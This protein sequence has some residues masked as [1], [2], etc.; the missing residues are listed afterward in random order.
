MAKGP[1]KVAGAGGLDEF[2]LVERYL[3]PLAGPGG[4]GLVDDAAVLVPPDGRELVMT[5]DTLVA[6]VH[7]PADEAPAAIAAKALR[8]NLSDLAAMGAQPWVYT[9]NLGL[10]SAPHAAWM[11]PFCDALAAD[12][13]TFGIELVGGDTVSTPGAA[14]FTVTALGV[15]APGRA[16]RRGGGRPG[17]DVWVSGSVG[18]AGLGL[19]LVTGDLDNASD[20]D[21]RFL[22]ERYRRPTPR[23]GLGLALAELAGIGAAADVSDGLVADLG[24]VCAASGCA[25]EIF[26]DSIPLS[27]SAV[28]LVRNNQGL[29]RSLLTSGDDYELVF[30]AVAAAADSVAALATTAGVAVTRIGRLLPGNGVQVLATPTGPP[31]EVMD[32]G[33]RHFR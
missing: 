16:L 28:S 12:Q 31:I 30:T 1:D 2:G 26:F 10:A 18:D 25:A 24:K 11:T 3:A 32:G 5:S 19:G 13:A 33:Y 6:G 20:D 8:V 23:L 7:F 29:H 17:D 21:R 22:V 9:L 14:S 15:V 27:D 4:L